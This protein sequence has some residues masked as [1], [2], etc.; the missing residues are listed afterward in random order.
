MNQQGS[1]LQAKAKS[2]QNGRGG[3]FFVMN[4]KTLFASMA[5]LLHGDSAPTKAPPKKKK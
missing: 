4:D 2:S 3:L 5:S 1:L